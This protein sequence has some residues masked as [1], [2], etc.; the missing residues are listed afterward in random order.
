M[1]YFR[2][3]PRSRDFEQ[4]PFGG[5]LSCAYLEH[6]CVDIKDTI[7]DWGAKIQTGHVTL[8]TPIGGS[9]SSQG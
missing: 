7:G 4:I 8:I 1:M 6:L 2:K 9:L 5:N 3:F